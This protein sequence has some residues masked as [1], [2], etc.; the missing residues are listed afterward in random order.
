MS[1]F[2]ATMHQIR[3]RLGLRGPS[4]LLAVFLGPSPYFEGEGRTGRGK[5][6][7]KGERQGRGQE[8]EAEGKVDKPIPQFTFLAVPLPLICFFF[9]FFVRPLWS[10]LC[11]RLPSV[12]SL[13]SLVHVLW[14]NGTY[15]QKTV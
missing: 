7:E 8:R 5:E 15:Y 14:L 4:D 13:L 3:F 2:K 9:S 11:H 12:F 10:N 1:H 6:G